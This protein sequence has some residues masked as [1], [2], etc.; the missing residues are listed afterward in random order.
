MHIATLMYTT[1]L[2]FAVRVQNLLNSKGYNK[3]EQNFLNSKGY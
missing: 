2:E 3:T 1:N